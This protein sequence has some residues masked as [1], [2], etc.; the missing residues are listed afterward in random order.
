MPSS[1]MVSC[2]IESDIF[3]NWSLTGRCPSAESSSSFFRCTKTS[4]ESFTC[5]LKL[6]PRLAVKFFE[7][8]QFRRL[9]Y[10]SPAFSC[11]EALGFKPG[12]TRT[13]P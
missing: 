2:R 9:F 5:L 3:R 10:C 4:K 6:L 13:D 12:E 7:E 8:G 11:A 1:S